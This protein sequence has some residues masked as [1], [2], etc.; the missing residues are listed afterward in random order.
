MMTGI[1]THEDW[2]KGRISGRGAMVARW[3]S[4]AAAPTFAGMALVAAL[5]P[6][7]MICGAMQGPLSLQG[8]VPMYALMSAFHLAPW[9]RL[10]R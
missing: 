2:L 6:A 7:D 3:L 9:L 8:M 1:E 4:L 10:F 5:A